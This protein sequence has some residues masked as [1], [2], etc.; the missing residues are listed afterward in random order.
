MRKKLM[1]YMLCILLVFMGMQGCGGHVAQQEEYGEYIYLSL[2]CDV[3]FWKA[4]QW[5][6]GEDSI[7]GKISRKTGVALNTA[8]PPEDADNQVRLMLANDK[9]TD[10]VSVT[11]STTISQMASSGK[12]WD[13]EEFFKKYLPDAQFL[14]N[15]PEDVKQALIK[16]DGGWYAF[17]S[18]LARGDVT[19]IWKASSE[20]YEDMVEY[21][22]N[23]GIIWNRKILKELGLEVENLRTQ[24][25]VMEA[26]EKAAQAN[27]DREEEIIPLMLDGQDYEDHSLTFFLETFGAEHVDVKGNYMDNIRQPE[28]KEALAYLNK[29]VQKGYFQAEWFNLSNAQIKRMIAEGNVLCFVGN[30]ANIDTEI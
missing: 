22:S 16:R 8:I 7:T 17:P 23:S 24:E 14:K 28:A 1:C 29:I 12:F 19:K 30:T 18:H 26:F 10:F 15:F 25:Q 6:T 4:P 3:D 27:R 5:D 21:L 11:N 20:C 13:L 9:L 2:F